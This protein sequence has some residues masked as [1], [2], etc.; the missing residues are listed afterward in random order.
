MKKQDKR[1]V[2]GIKA[3]AL[4][5]LALFV[6]LTRAYGANEWDIKITVPTDTIT[7][8]NAVPIT[9]TVNGFEDD[10]ITDVKLN[11]DSNPENF[12]EAITVKFTYPQ[13]RLLFSTRL[14]LASTGNNTISALVRLK[15]GR[16]VKK[17]IQTGNIVKPVNFTDRDSLSA[18]MLGGVSFPTNEIGQAVIYARA[19]KDG[20]QTYTVKGTLHHPMLPKMEGVKPNFVDNI[21]V[22]INEEKYIS[23]E[24][25][26]VLSND[27]FIWI[28]FTVQDQITNTK[29]IW[30]DSKGKTFEATAK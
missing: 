21:D 28:D 16:M 27:P 12:Q 30:R 3:S 13:A 14:R 17:T 25:T 11:V 5:I 7:V 8:A 4:L 1:R 18:I 15:S 20:S 24:S 22:L 9:L 2:H 19:A 23:I 26:P 6:S 10:S 29:M